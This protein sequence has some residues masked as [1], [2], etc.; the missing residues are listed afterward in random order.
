MYSKER[1][2]DRSGFAS[3]DDL[4]ALPWQHIYSKLENY[5]QRFLDNEDKF[6]S[7]SY[8]WPSAPLQ[9]WSR[10]WEYPYVAY[11]VDRWQATNL[12]TKN[13]SIVDLGSGVTF[14]PLWL[15]SE[16][17]QVSAVDNDPIGIRD[18]PLA[19]SA[20]NVPQENLKFHLSDANNLPFDDNS[21]DC[22]FSISVLEHIP[23]PHSVID[24]IFRV[25]K[26]NGLFILTIDVSLDGV[27]EITSGPFLDLQEALVRHFSPVFP[28]L[29]HYK[30]RNLKD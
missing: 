1:P 11:H 5:Q 6:R 22:V 2:F 25:L 9:K 15:A 17:Y 24:E 27:H 29:H 18:Y 26:P 23:K 13:L 14:F 8:I 28:D 30:T 20:L 3:L 21:V 12:L 4:D 19:C 16:G 10:V 7:P